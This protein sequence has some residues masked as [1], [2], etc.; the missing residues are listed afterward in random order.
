[1]GSFDCIIVGA[2]SAGCVLANRLSRNPS[3]RVLLLEAGGPDRDPRIGIPGAYGF[4]FGS[5]SDWGLWSE[6]Q[7]GLGGRRLY[8][9]RGRTLG[10][11]SSTNAMAY[12]RGNPVDYDRWA[13]AGNR[14]WSY[15]ELLPRFIRAER[16]E[17]VERLDPGYHGTRGGLHVAFAD[18]FRSP[19]AAAF[20]ESGVQA[21]LARNDDCNGARQAGVGYFQFTIRNGRR[22]SAAD[23]FLHPAMGRGN[24]EVITGRRVEKL[25]FRGE[26]CTGVRLDDGT[27]MT[28]RSEVVLA[29]GAFHTPQLLM[30]SGIGPSEEL[31][32]HGIDV[33]I[34]SPGVGR[35]LHDHLFFPV[36]CR[37]RKGS[38]V[39]PALGAL[40]GLLA[41]ARYL[42]G[43]R[44]P[45]TIGPLEA[46]AFLDSGW[47]E[48][49]RRSERTPL[50]S[51]PTWEG[52]GAPDL[53]LQFAPLHAGPGYGYDMYD[54]R[55]YPIDDGFTILPSLLHPRSRGS[56]GL[57]SNR[58][59]DPPR[60]DPAALDDPRDLETLAR[61]AH[62]ARR[63][64]EQPALADLVI[65]AHTPVSYDRETLERHIRRS[66]ETIYHPVGTCRMGPDTDADAVVDDR[67]RVRGVEGLRVAD[68]S[69][70]PEI[71]SGNTNAPVM[72]IA[73]R[74]ADFITGGEEFG[75]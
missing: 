22:W 45:L 44:G 36:S 37:T 58:I 69:V 18:R 29:A 13:A 73:E 41:G 49:K 11:S 6:P 52:S 25:E 65:D 51:G 27:V 32:P 71:V 50:D 21:G 40:G 60:I 38:G 55:T 34:E 20:V 4:L 59:Q 26:R 66:V 19:A 70:M 56:L 16:A 28:A 62:I 43:R 46:V 63:I 17:H 64:L 42:V 9:P 74:A 61:G 67:L 12:V 31:R 75:G 14:G 33:R 30:L 2:G 48:G 39:N 10:G 54:P 57:R 1:M 53:Q 35:N 3:R 8:L 72:A 68:A 47:L 15:D 23:A 7:A 24:L 5:R